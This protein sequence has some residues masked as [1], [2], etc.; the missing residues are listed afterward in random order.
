VFSGDCQF[1]RQADAKAVRLL[2]A[3]MAFAFSVTA[4]SAEHAVSNAEYGFSVR[5][6][7]EAM[8]CESRSGDH[9][10]GFYVNLDKSSRCILPASGVPFIAMGI[11]ADWNSFFVSS[12]DEI[13]A[14]YCGGVQP[15]RS[16]VERLKLGNTEGRDSTGC[17]VDR[18]D[19]FVQLYVLLAAGEESN[20]D[21][22]GKIVPKVIYLISLT[23]TNRRF[24]RD[25]DQFRE[26]VRSIRITY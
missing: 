6:P 15:S 2:L 7:K 10:H 16:L 4:C 12:L 25:L 22:A 24:D 5:F 1:G 9:V 17:R 18:S 11:Y 3:S 26:M 13:A 20:S 8:V 14:Q 19:G 23:S 21:S